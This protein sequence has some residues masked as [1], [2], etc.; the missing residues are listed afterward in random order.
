MIILIVYADV[1]VFLNLIVDYFLL[2]ATA[3]IIK[4]RT[5]VLRMVLASFIG[6]VSSLYIFFEV[7]NIFIE[8]VIKL[9]FCLV[10]V[11]TAFGFLGVKDFLRNAIVLFLVMCGY[12]GLM[13]AVWYAFKPNG[14]VIN[15][16][17]VYFN[18]ST[19]WLVV[20]TVA[21]YFI[22]SLLKF[23]FSKSSQCAKVCSVW[24][25]ANNKSCNFEA[26]VD[27][28]NSLE[29]VYGKSEI[30]I[31]DS[32][33]VEKLFGSTD[34]F[35][36]KI[37]PRYRL[38]PCGTVAGN[39]FLDGVRCDSGIITVNNKKITLDKPILAVSKLPLKDGYQ[40]IVN[41]KIIC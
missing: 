5:K 22:L 28:G 17:V 35:S 26:I 34:Y 11:L 36:S 15:N 6:G 20:F 41:P 9:G 2:L 25:S 8:T 10:M 23:V 4:K 30:I 32:F 13:I 24:V 3:K 19:V 1:L 16:S 29:D 40:G 12:S 39:S 21:A 33:C 18:I 31:V 14:M 7:S 37:S 38:L 27:T